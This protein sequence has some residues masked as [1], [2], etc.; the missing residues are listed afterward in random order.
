MLSVKRQIAAK[1]ETEE[2]V[3]EEL[4]EAD[5]KLLA[6]DPK[7]TFEPER[8]PQTASPSSLSKRGKLTGKIPAAFTF[9][10][11]LRGSGTLGTASEWAKILRAC[12]IAESALKSVAIGAVTGGPFLHGETITGSISSAQGR[13]VIET[14][15]GAPFIYYVPISGDIQDG[16]NITGEISGASVPVSASP[17]AAG[18]EYKLTSQELIVPSLTMGCIDDGIAKRIRGTRGNSVF[19]FK[20]GEP[21]K[22]NFTHRGV[23]EDVI[24]LPMLSIVHETTKPPIFQNAALTI[25]NYAARIGELTIDLGSKLAEDEDANAALGI[26]CFTIGDREPVGT[27]NPKMVLGSVNDFYNHWFSDE[28][29]RLDFTIGNTPGNKFRFYMPKIQYEKIEDETRDG[30]ALANISFSLNQNMEFGD[31]ELTILAL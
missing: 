20:A 10:L 4:S 18:L 30:L 3:A 22:I 2:G 15:T 24:D 8:L 7:I 26:R 19:N 16:E 29:K 13:V 14:A 12:G 28:E 5:A 27:M 17:I 23:K 1:I 31:D 9:M 6:F 21:C 11:Q 25:G